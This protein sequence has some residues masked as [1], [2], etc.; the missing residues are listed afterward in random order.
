M[1]FLTSCHKDFEENET[2]STTSNPPQI[3]NEINGSVLGYVYDENN[4]P[5]ADVNITI[6]SESTTTDT[7]GA[8]VMKGGALTVQRK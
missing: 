1:V 3:F 2:I 5:V 8:I 6:Y 7:N 4:L